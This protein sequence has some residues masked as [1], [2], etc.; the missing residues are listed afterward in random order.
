MTSRKKKHLW[1]L[2]YGICSLL[3]MAWMVHLS[4][5]NFD[6]VHRHYRLAGERL[7]PARIEAIAREEL[8]LKCRKEATRVG[9]LPGSVDPCQSWPEAVLKARQKKVEQRL[10][11]E[12]DLAWRKLVIFYLSFG[13]IFLILPPLCLRLLIALAF[14]ILRNLKLIK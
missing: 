10:V 8:E 1:R 5:Y 12:H 6:M 7:H 4:L 11:A 9:L 14:L 3:Y 13:T 2:A